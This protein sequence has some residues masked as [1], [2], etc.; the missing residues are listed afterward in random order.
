MILLG[1]GV[2]ANVVLAKSKENASGLIVV[3]TG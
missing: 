1:A 2:V 3:T